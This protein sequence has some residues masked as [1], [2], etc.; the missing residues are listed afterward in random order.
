MNKALKILTAASLMLTVATTAAMAANVQ[1]APKAATP[2]GAD[3]T[4]SVSAYP[5]NY[6]DGSCYDTA[7][8][9]LG[10]CSIYCHAYSSIP[11]KRSIQFTAPKV[12]L[13]TVHITGISQYPRLYYTPKVEYG[14][15]VRV[16]YYVN[17]SDS[18]VIANGSIDG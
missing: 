3:R 4:W 7:D 14:D 16:D 8:T 15:S 9:N 18:R 17:G 6:D 13:D 2:R 1:D 10:Y 11:S 5:M 12:S